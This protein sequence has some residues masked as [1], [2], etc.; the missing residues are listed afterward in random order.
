MLG[1]K[2]RFQCH[3]LYYHIFIAI[4][5]PHL[6]ILYGAMKLHVALGH[7]GDGAGALN[8]QVYHCQIFKPFKL[9]PVLFEP[10]FNDSTTIAIDNHLIARPHAFRINFSS[11][12]PTSI[13]NSI[14]LVKSLC[15]KSAASSSLIPWPNSRCSCA[16][17]Q[18]AS[19]AS[20]PSCAHSFPKDAAQWSRRDP[21]NSVVPYL[22]FSD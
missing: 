2:R 9:I 13:H 15:H 20:E 18:K 14:V 19:K 6:T 21:G 17:K 8:R 10:H 3:K 7:F 1:G 4:T 12:M 16:F 11:G 5:Q 22:R